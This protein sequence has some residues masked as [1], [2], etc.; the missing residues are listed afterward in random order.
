MSIRL[1]KS[2]TPST[3]NRAISAFTEITKNKP[4]KKL[5]SKN[6]YYYFNL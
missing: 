2:Y 3:R 1:Y 5:I 4:E 6:S